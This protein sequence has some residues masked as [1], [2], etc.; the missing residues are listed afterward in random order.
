MVRFKANRV[1]PAVLIYFFTYIMLSVLA[2]F[3]PN[4]MAIKLVG[5]FTLGYAFILFTY[6]TAWAVALWYVNV[7]QV[8]F[9]PL[10][11]LAIES[12]ETEGSAS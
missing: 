9:D 1:R 3:A 2:G 12:I 8:E 10:K 4:V 5:S 7:A 11:Q 6:L